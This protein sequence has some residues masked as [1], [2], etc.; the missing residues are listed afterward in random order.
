MKTNET[1]KEFL[2]KEIVRK[3]SNDWQFIRRLAGCSLI[4]GAIVFTLLYALL[5]K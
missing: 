2:L 3:D 1:E 5:N 4:L